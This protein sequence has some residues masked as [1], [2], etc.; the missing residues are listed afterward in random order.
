MS[1]AAG[2]I[3]TAVVFRAAIKQ[4]QNAITLGS[5]REGPHGLI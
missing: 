5:N 3:K 1:N 4:T 2:Q